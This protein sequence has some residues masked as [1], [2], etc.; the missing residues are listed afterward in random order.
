M[1]RRNFL[2][3]TGAGVLAI[4]NLARASAQ[5]SGQAMTVLGPIVPARLGRTLVHEHVMVD[6]IGAEAIRPGRYDPEDVF[7]KALPYLRQAKSGG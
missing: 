7:E 1:N 5:Q 4:S 3:T 2:V 6:F